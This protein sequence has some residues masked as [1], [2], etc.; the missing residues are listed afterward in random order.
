MPFRLDDVLILDLD[1]TCKGC[2][3][4]LTSAELVP[5]PD[6]SKLLTCPRCQEPFPA[7]AQGSRELYCRSGIQ[8]NSGDVIASH[9]QPLP[10]ASRATS[11]ASQTLARPQPAGV[12]QT[13]CMLPPLPS[14]PYKASQYSIL[15]SSIAP[16]MV[17]CTPPIGL[18]AG[19]KL[20]IDR[21]AAGVTG[22]FP[23]MVTWRQG[24]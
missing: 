9:K 20:R 11:Y 4:R 12:R 14:S 16:L 24:T 15:Q 17:R 6:G 10:A 22:G 3:Y 23:F 19:T 5:R 13:C 21:N 2:K 1:V 8:G 18:H 7:A